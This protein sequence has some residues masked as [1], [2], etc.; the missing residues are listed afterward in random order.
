MFFESEVFIAEIWLRHKLSGSSWGWLEA[1]CLGQAG[2]K[3]KERRNTSGQRPQSHRWGCQPGCRWSLG[4][5][6]R[7]MDFTFLCYKQYLLSHQFPKRNTK[8]SS[9]N[10]CVSCPKTTVGSAGSPPLPFVL[11]ARPCP[12]VTKTSF[13][14]RPATT[15]TPS[16]F[17]APACSTNCGRW[18]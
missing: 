5:A 10:K 7:F 3:G 11:W 1:L 2:E 13:T 14:L 12:S 18:V 16:A 4:H 8:E 6:L 17:R 9:S 15:W